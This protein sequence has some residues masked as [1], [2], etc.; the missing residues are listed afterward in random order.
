MYLYQYN[1]SQLSK[2]NLFNYFCHSMFEKLNLFSQVIDLEQFAKDPELMTKTVTQFN[3]A[4]QQ[5]LI[6]AGKQSQEQKIMDPQQQKQIVSELVKT[7]GFQEDMQLFKETREL[8]LDSLFTTCGIDF[9][10]QSNSFCDQDLIL[11]LI[12]SL[13]P[14]LL[15]DTIKQLAEIY[16]N[17][18]DSESNLTPH[19]PELDTFLT[20]I[21]M[22]QLTITN[23]P[24]SKSQWIRLLY[25]QL[26]YC[27][28]F[29]QSDAVILNIPVGKHIDIAL[30]QISKCY[31][32]SLYKGGVGLRPH[33]RTTCDYESLEEFKALDVK[34]MKYQGR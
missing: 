31:F 25:S 33:W 13:Y 32:L 8:L 14:K 19:N 17:C 27:G 24:P 21:K 2:I 15:P 1:Q 11:H 7:T 4:H 22:P 16:Y 29:N 3:T 26:D 28:E 23:Q 30:E 10:L 6:K 5:A 34:R 12:L 9:M 20:L 18:V